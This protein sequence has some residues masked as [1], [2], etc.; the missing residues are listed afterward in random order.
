MESLRSWIVCVAL[1]PPRI[2]VHVIAAQFPEARFVARREAQALDPLR[3]L[4][5]VK[6]R[7]EKPGRPTVFRFEWRAGKAR[8]DHR[9]ATDQISHRQVGVVIV[10]RQREKVG[11]RRRDTCG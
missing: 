3:T 6:M 8:R 5:E 1:L 7:D 11:R 4:P 9:L 10:M 2:A